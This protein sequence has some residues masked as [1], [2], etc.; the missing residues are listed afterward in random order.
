[1][2]LKYKQV[3]MNDLPSL[4]DNTYDV[5]ILEMHL[6]E[7]AEVKIYVGK[8]RVAEPEADRQFSPQQAATRTFT[9]I[10]YWWDE[11]CTAFVTHDY[12]SNDGSVYLWFTITQVNR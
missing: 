9:S 3:D 12:L 2:D 5:E 4:R 10:A 7:E 1:M 8:A 11:N 6:L